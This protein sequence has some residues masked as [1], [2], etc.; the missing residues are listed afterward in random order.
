M[1]LIKLHLTAYGNIHNRT[2]IQCTA[3]KYCTKSIINITCSHNSNSI[4]HDTVQ[5]SLMMTSALQTK[6]PLPV[7]VTHKRM[8]QLI[9]KNSN[10]TSETVQAD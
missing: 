10:A 2:R 1:L 5:P 6:T 4:C 7:H 8:S 3:D 9:I